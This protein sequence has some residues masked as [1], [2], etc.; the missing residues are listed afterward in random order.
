MGPRPS[1]TR[2]LIV[3]DELANVLL[4]ERILDQADYT[5]HTVTTDPRQ[6]PASTLGTTPT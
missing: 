2:I 5:N 6:V 4:L 3:D 1:D